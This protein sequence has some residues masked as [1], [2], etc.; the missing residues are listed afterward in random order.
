[1]IVVVIKVNNRNTISNND[2]CISNNSNS[3]YKN[4]SSN[5]IGELILK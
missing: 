3:S 2:S 5:N 4:S 1:M